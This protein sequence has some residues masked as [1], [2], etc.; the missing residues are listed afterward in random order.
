MVTGIATIT[1]DAN[2]A[3][4][5]AYDTSRAVKIATAISTSKP[6]SRPSPPP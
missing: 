3:L 4:V 1:G 2:A 6:S 5:A